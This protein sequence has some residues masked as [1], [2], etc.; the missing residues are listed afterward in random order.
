MNYW[1]VIGEV[2][3]TRLGFRAGKTP[4][5]LVIFQMVVTELSVL[6]C[7]GACGAVIK[8]EC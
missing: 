4:K 6:S 7:C 5:R 2:R 8:S 3:M 1:P